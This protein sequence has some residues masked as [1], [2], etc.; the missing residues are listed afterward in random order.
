MTGS[1]RVPLSASRPVASP[2][3]RRGGTTKLGAARRL[4][5]SFNAGSST[6]KLGLFLLGEAGLQRI[7]TGLLDGRQPPWQ[8][9][10]TLG[11][12]T[13]LIP[14]PALQGD[15]WNP[16]I[17]HALNALD[18]HLPA[19][20][21]AAV[22]H[23]VVHGGDQ[24]HGPTLITDTVLQ[25]ITD[26]VPLAP[27]HQP[28]SLRWIQALRQWRPQLPQVAAF[29]TAFHT[30]ASD[31][32]RRYAIARSFFNEGI[33][34]YGFHGLSYQSI[35]GQL[36]RA[37]P[38]LAVGKVVVAHLGSGASLCALDG[39]QSRDTSMGFSTLDGIPMAT[40]CGAIDPGVL[41]HWWEQGV[42]LSEVTQRLYA[43]SG[44]LGLSGISADSRALLASSRPEAAEALAVLALRIAGE[45]ARLA[46]TLGGLDGLV[47]TA[48]MGE[49]Q[50]QVR[51]AVCH[52]LAWLGVQL[53]ATA[54]AH[55]QG[56]LHASSSRV[57]VLM[58]HTDEEQVMA[59]QAVPLLSS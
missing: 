14:L 35:A 34:R 36:R 26:L 11:E 32:V 6:L 46:T 19:A 31:V 10:L 28:Q 45:V 50:P 56:A 30:T 25:A 43:Q 15:D 18:K 22:V 21:W 16:V 12:A 17:D 27:L 3:A 7:G 49:H 39:C 54:N 57:A 52:H 42:S 33:K 44:L 58:L 23:R 8:L 53:D 24:F 1:P 37:H 13:T 47:F 51:A 29:D 40:R 41:L 48:G 59:D 38:D 55:N 5:L 2:Q 20:E 9:A 4:L